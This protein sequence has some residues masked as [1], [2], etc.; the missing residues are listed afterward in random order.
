MH[1]LLDNLIATLVAGS[2]FLIL[3]GINHR[4]QQ[5]AF[6]AVNFYAMRQQQIAFIDMLKRD[7][8]NVTRLETAT[9]QG[10]E[11]ILFVTEPSTSNEI[12]V[13]YR[14]EPVIGTDYVRIQ[15][16]EIQG[17]SQV[18]AGRSA[19]TISHWQIVARNAASQPVVDP[20]AATQVYINFEMGAP[21]RE[22]RIVKR[23]RWD[24]AF[25]PPMLQPNVSI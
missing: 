10:N 2:V 3:I 12:R 4:N 14:R 8:Q 6:E 7:M 25:R 22:G 13:I 16:Y 18:A 24:A 15:R 23:A 17:S 19:D 5:A 11:F 20:T 21:F 9:E 1:F